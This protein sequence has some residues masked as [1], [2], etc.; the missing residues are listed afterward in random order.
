MRAVYARD[1]DRY[2]VAEKVAALSN[3][4]YK[5]GAAIFSGNR[6]LSVG[7]NK[8]KTHPELLRYGKHVVSIHAELDCILRANTSIIGSAIYIA[9]LGGKR[10][11]YP[12]PICLSIILTAGIKEIIYFDGNALI[13]DKL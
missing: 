8:L 13:K 11:S 3:C 7:H 2:L 6:C 12:C 5:L 10:I 4:R 9:R 1:Y